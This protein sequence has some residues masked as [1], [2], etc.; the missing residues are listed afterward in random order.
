[1]IENLDK[2]RVRIQRDGKIFQGPVIYWMSRDQRLSDNWALI[3]AQQIALET[4]SELVVL[5]YLVR[6][7][8]DATIR[9]Y[10]FM[11]RGLQKVEFKLKEKNIPFHIILGDPSEEIPEFIS[12]IKASILISDFDP[13]KIKRHWKKEIAKKIAIPFHEVD[14]HNIVPCFIASSKKELGAYTLRPKILKLLPQFL[15]EFP[16]IL[17][18]PYN[19]AMMPENNFSKLYDFLEVDR[20]VKP[21]SI[22]SGEDAGIKKLKDVI[23]TKLYGY[24]TFRND[25][26]LDYQ[27]GLSPYLHFGQLSAQRVALEVKNSN[28]QEIDKKA[29]LEELIIRKELSDNFCLYDD[30]YDSYESFPLWAIETLRKHNKDKRDYIYSIQELEHAKTH[31]IYWNSAQKEMVLTGKMHGYMRMYWAKKILEWTEN[32]EEAQKIAIY[33]NDKYELDGR[34]PNGY[35]GIAWS[36]GGVHDRPWKERPIF[37]KIRYMSFEGLKRKFNMDGYIK[38]INNLERYL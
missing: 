4:K 6:K 31:D 15:T 11:I 2:R 14:A 33:L 28:A 10:D 21:V 24:A 16:E 18:H 22:E 26:S 20:T 37:G 9:Q 7:F 35:A 17:K 13:L 12:K 23:K 27:S 3:Y 32:F 38:R 19:K 29:F 36:I 5:F 34:D 25:P 1:M 30:N 8:L